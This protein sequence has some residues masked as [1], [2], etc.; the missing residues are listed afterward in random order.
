MSSLLKNESS[1]ILA[2]AL[3][4]ALLKNKIKENKHRNE[5]I[6]N[7][8]DSIIS[9]I[10]TK[11]QYNV[12]VETLLDLYFLNDDKNINTHNSL[13]TIIPNETAAYQFHQY[14]I[15][16]ILKYFSANRFTFHDHFKQF[17]TILQSIM[18]PPDTSSLI[19]ASLFKSLVESVLLICDQGTSVLVDSVG[20]LSF[21]C[22]ILQAGL[23]HHI[24]SPYLI[25]N[26]IEQLIANGVL[27]TTS[28][29][30]CNEFF[31]LLADE[32]CESL[33]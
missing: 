4:L 28:I 21:I 15:S 31:C 7:I 6:K 33:L 18:K 32:L 11:I 29:P 17:M 12:P 9:N 24:R 26:D 27:G 16:R 5:N 3:G 23:R 2:I 22:V 19:L 10:Y 1:T 20:R 25:K 13:N 14:M 30:L 8:D